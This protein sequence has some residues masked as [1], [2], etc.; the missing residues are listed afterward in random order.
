M[1]VWQKVLLDVLQEISHVL[2]Q[3][4]PHILQH[5]ELPESVAKFLYVKLAHIKKEHFRA[6]RPVEVC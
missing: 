2:R 6:L 5:H 3:H 1:V 4:V